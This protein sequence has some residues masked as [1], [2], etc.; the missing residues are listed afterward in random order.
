MPKKMPDDGLLKLF[1]H[2]SHVSRL[3]SPVSTSKALSNFAGF[4]TIE[5]VAQPRNTEGRGIW[6]IDTW[7]EPV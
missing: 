6:T 7:V 1:L 2:G 4:V 3:I 5:K